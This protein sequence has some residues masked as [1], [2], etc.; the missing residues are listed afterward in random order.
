MG[1]PEAGCISVDEDVTGER[2][3]VDP[4]TTLGDELGITARGITD[5]MGPGTF[6]AE[7][8]GESESPCWKWELELKY[9][10]FA[11]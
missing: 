10:T 1:I 5:C 11:G 6:A 9:G 4:G 3:G 7:G 8:S 2:R